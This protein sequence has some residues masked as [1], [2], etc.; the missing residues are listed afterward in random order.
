MSENLR[1]IAISD[2]AFTK[3]PEG[4][5]EG[6]KKNEKVELE[7]VPKD[8]IR[9]IKALAIFGMAMAS[10]SKAEMPDQ[11]LEDIK[12]Q[13]AREDLPPLVDAKYFADDAYKQNKPYVPRVI[14]HPDSQ[15]KGS[16]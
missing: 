5:C 4:F 3:L 11:Q 8:K 15:K 13:L 14:G 10:V 6:L 16:R 1:K 9:G 2:D 12:K 7:V